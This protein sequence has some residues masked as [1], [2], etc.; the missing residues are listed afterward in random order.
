M[1]IKKLT[2]EQLEA[3]KHAMMNGINLVVEH[4]LFEI[5]QELQKRKKQKS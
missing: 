2:T 1:N 5:E 4:T 3:I